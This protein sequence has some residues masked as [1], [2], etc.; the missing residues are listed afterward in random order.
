M[1]IKNVLFYLN[2]IKYKQPLKNFNERIVKNAL[3]DDAL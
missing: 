2:S 1:H 3:M